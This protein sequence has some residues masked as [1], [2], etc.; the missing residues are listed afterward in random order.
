MN[1]REV[2]WIEAFNHNRYSDIAD[3]SKYA[4]QALKEFDRRFNKNTHL[5]ESSPESGCDTVGKNE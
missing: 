2:A 3:C 5:T 1:V 4:D